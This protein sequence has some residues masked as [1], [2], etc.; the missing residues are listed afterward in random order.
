M[1]KLDINK[2][3]P[4]KGKVT[5][6]ERAAAT[7][8]KTDIKALFTPEPN[9]NFYVNRA[10]D[11]D[12]DDMVVDTE[13]EGETAKGKKRKA[14]PLRTDV[15]DEEEPEVDDTNIVE[16]LLQSNRE[17]E[18]KA[19]A[20]EN[21]L[22]AARANMRLLAQ[23]HGIKPHEVNDY[24]L[25]M[26]LNADQIQAAEDEANGEELVTTASGSSTRTEP[27]LRPVKKKKSSTSAKSAS[28]S[29]HTAKVT[30]KPV[31]EGPES[32]RDA[33]FRPKE[34]PSPDKEA[35]E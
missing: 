34:T 15:S 18:D 26:E 1:P 5:L 2:S 6:N 21:E 20:L 11:I 29:K 12:S 19:S 33:Y 9:L 14:P 28:G 4:D 27:T 16:D 24:I 32:V 7:T 13:E 8:A 23:S 22:K 30:P 25:A 31:C 10:A 3:A 17:A 35:S